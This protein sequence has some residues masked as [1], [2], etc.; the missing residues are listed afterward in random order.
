MP[1]PYRFACVC[2]LTN[3][4][5]CAGDAAVRHR[6]P[7][8]RHRFF[9]VDHRHDCGPAS[10]WCTRY[11]L[12]ADVC[13]V[14]LVESHVVCW[15]GVPLHRRVLFTVASCR[16]CSVSS[17]VRCGDRRPVPTLRAGRS[18]LQLARLLPAVLPFCSDGPLLRGYPRV[19]FCRSSRPLL[20]LGTTPKVIVRGSRRLRFAVG[21]HLPVSSRFAVFWGRSTRT[22]G[23]RTLLTRCQGPVGVLLFSCSWGTCGTAPTV[24]R[25]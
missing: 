13:L 8:Q 18:V 14:V 7:Q 25:A 23:T 15:V 5:S 3:C 11:P 2:T 17:L 1:R 22:I 21:C 24:A 4:R 20:R 6:S 9:L 12:P 19:L 16:R 10:C